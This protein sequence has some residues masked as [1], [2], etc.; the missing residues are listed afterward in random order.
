MKNKVKVE[1][2][3]SK[4]IP[5][6]YLFPYFISQFILSKTKY[7]VMGKAGFYPPGIEWLIKSGQRSAK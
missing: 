7:S 2:K 3:L 1:L 4:T 6:L 5:K